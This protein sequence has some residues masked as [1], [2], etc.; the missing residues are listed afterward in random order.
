MRTLALIIG[1][2][3]YY[4]GA[5]LDNAVNDA[6]SIQKVFER[7]G[8]EIIFEN[9]CKREKFGHLLFEFENRIVDYDASIIYFAGH[10]FELEGENYLAAIEAGIS[11]RACL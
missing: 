5:K 10:G 4:K 1:N 9:D 3:E 8:F 2:N 11:G 7:L 6:V